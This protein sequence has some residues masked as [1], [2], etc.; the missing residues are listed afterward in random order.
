MAA[1]AAHD[2]H[3]DVHA[4][5]HAMSGAGTDEATI[6][7][8]FTSRPRA[9]LALVAHAY[10]EQHGHTLESDIKGDTSGNFKAL[11]LGLMTPL[12]DYL[13]D[14]IH[15][16]VSR[17]GTNER[18]LIDVIT[19]VSFEELALMKEAWTR[20]HHGTLEHAV[21]G[22]TGHNFR[23]VLMEALKGTRMLPGHV[24]HSLVEK[25]AEKLY[26]A[27]EGRLGTNEEAFIEVL[28]RSSAAHIQAVSQHYEKHH[29]HHSLETA[30]KSETSGDFEH[31]LLA[32]CTPR[33]TYVAQRIYDAV[34]GL[35]TN[36]SLL[37]RMFCINDRA[38]IHAAAAEFLRLY[39]K[40]M[41]RAIR[42]DTSGDYKD[43]LLHLLH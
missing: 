20:K 13:C 36:D 31:V 18:E 28:S 3:H 34:N 17:P 19:Q 21:A 10:K 32:L 14:C 4:L 39:G 5:H 16:A 40:P 7:E 37:I 1:T 33:P 27:G 42:G 30:I 9:H 26:K 11:L 15:E 43:L 2:V 38:M 29:K 25:D 23:K 22:D 12:G 24:E 6:I 41:E 8:I 35:G